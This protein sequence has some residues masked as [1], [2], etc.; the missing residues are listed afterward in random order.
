MNFETVVTAGGVSAL[1]L[2]GIK[3]LWRKFVAK[4]M[5]YEFP[6]WFYLVS[7]PILNIAVVPLLALVGF[8][9][10]TMPT[11]WVVWIQNIIQIFI[12]SLI[13]TFAY[14]NVVAPFNAYRAELKAKS[15]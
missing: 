6:A 10:F 3:W 11:D 9:G 14:N 12:G 5:Q 15:Q 8:V 1:V 7:V 4:D 2:Q 13:S